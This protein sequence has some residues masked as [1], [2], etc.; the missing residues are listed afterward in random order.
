MT[1]A[2]AII[3]SQLLIPTRYRI[4]THI[5]YTAICMDSHHFVSGGL[6]APSMAL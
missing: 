4:T 5:P 2:T 6:A 3:I 1:L